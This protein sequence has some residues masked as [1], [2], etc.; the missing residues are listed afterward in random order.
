MSV[1]GQY[2]ESVSLPDSLL[3]RNIRDLHS[4]IIAGIDSNSA[5]IIDIPEHA[6]A[7]LSFIQLM[8]SARRHAKAQGKSIALSSPATG[9]ILKVLERAG[10]IEAFNPDDAKFWLHKEVTP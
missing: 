2:R 10:F 9:Q 5:V 8:E 3:I 4:S 6:D 7:D 1:S